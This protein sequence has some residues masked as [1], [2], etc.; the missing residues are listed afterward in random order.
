M[1][2]F[3]QQFNNSFSVRFQFSHSIKW[4]ER[5]S[6][7]LFWIFFFSSFN[8]FASWFRCSVFCGPIRAHYKDTILSV[9]GLFAVVYKC[10]STKN[11]F[12]VGFSLFTWATPCLYAIPFHNFQRSVA[13]NEHNEREKNDR[14][15]L[16][17]NND[18]A[19]TMWR[20]MVR[21]LVDLW[22]VCDSRRTHSTHTHTNR[23]AIPMNGCCEPTNTWFNPR[24]C[25]F[26]FNNFYFVSFFNSN[27]ISWSLII[28]IICEFQLACPTKIETNL[29]NQR[30]MISNRDSICII[31][32]THTHT[33]GLEPTS[34]HNNRFYEFTEIA[35]SFD[36]W[37]HTATGRG[38]RSDG[39]SKCLGIICA[40][41]LLF[42]HKT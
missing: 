26:I 41:A 22:R 25:Q 21:D 29:R 7:D 3:Q 36:S 34:E 38:R 42:S 5:N 24:H 1:Q 40:R 37:R 18:A 19:Y 10:L 27:K 33:L 17:K 16:R 31:S 30:E 35:R 14:K 6:P 15:K 8:F 28:C 39:R 2:W 11:I 9:C 32:H 20:L 13:I 23:D 12:R 4:N